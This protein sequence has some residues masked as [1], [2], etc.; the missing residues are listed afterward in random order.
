MRK[1]SKW[2]AVVLCLAVFAAMAMGS[3]TSRTKSKKIVASA[4]KA[5]SAEKSVVD[6]QSGETFDTEE[7][8]TVESARKIADE[9]TIKEQ[10]LLDQDGVKITAKGYESGGIIGDGIKLLIENNTEK[11]LMVSCKALIVN[12]FMIDDLFATEVAAGKKVNETMDLLSSGLKDAGI[13][14]VGKVEIYFHISDSDSYDTVFDSECITIQTSAFDKMDTTP[15]PDNVGQELYNA[16]GIRI[17]GKTVDEDSIWG[18]AILLYIENTS[19]KNV[20]INV[21][22]MSINGFMMSPL[23]STTVYDGKKAFEDITILSSDLEENNIET[24]EDVELK[25]HIYEAD[26]YETI[27]DTEPIKFTAK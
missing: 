21:D 26:S 20:G 10:V 7:K 9:V 17:V 11:N 6:Q 14:T 4:D 13:E 24:I 19:G 22:D 23:F 25:F 8:N 15:N 1:K 12:D 2:L 5:T 3:G 18:T 16:D 27:T